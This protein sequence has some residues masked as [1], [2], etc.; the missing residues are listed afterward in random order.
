V[1]FT[2]TTSNVGEYAE[3]PLPRAAPGYDGRRTVSALTTPGLTAAALVCSLAGQQYLEWSNFGAW[4]QLPLPG[5]DVNYGSDRAMN[6]AELFL[7]HD[8]RWHIIYHDYDTDSIFIR[9][10]Q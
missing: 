7:G 5:P 8:G 6:Q 9:S 1:R 2:P 10:T 3:L 4:E